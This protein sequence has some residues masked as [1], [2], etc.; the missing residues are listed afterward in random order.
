MVRSV[1]LLL[2]LALSALGQDVCRNGLFADEQD[3]LQLAR[4]TGGAPAVFLQDTAAGCPQKGAACGKKES[5]APGTELLVSKVR[6]GFAC[7]W[8]TLDLM[9]WIPAARLDL[10]VAFDRNPPATAWVGDWK[11]FDNH[12]E[13]AVLP[14]GKRLQVKGHAFWHGMSSTHEGSVAGDG[15]ASA[16]HLTIR[17]DGC[18]LRLT[19]VGRRLVAGDN[20][21][22][23]GANVRFTGVY[24]LARPAFEARSESTLKYGRNSD[25]QDTVD[26]VNVTFDLAQTA[27][28]DR[29]ILRKTH[30]EANVI[31]DMGND[32][33]ITVEAWPL[34]VDLKEK[35]RYAITVEGQSAAV[36]DNALLVID[37]TQEAPW[38]S[39]YHLDTGRP[40]F[41][42][43]APLARFSLTDVVQTPR[44]AGLEIPGDDIADKRLKAPGVVGVLTYADEDRVRREALITCDNVERAQV[45]RSFADTTFELA[46]ANKTIRITLTPFDPTGHTPA[47]VLLVPVVNDDLDLAH[48]RLPAGIRMGA[49]KR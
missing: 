49:W 40:F 8:Q 41:D 21:A 27:N 33:K 47:A 22:C 17:E 4:V 23:G 45:L 16:N 42:T 32:P 38:W 13:L 37:R 10:T 5:A 3:N 44:Y 39:V 43:F 26:I 30:T 6:N 2:F 11:V 28:Q 20:S 35:P 29:L 48:A 46:A 25:G 15:T 19:L 34:G 1:T 36:V 14:D 31:D 7:A 9:G 18:E 24:E 12:L